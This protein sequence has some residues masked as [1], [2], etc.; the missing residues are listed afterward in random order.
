MDLRMIFCFKQNASL[1]YFN[2]IKSIKRQNSSFPCHI[3]L[4]AFLFTCKKRGFSFQLNASQEQFQIHEIC[5]KPCKSLSYQSCCISFD[6]QE[7]GL[8]RGRRAVLNDSVRVKRG[9]EWKVRKPK[10]KNTSRDGGS[11]A[12]YA[13]CTVDTVDTFY[14]LQTALHCLN[15]SAYAYMLLGKGQNA[16][17]MG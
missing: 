14:S 7:K 10:E 1:E 9:R 13:A 8:R 6:P 4:A 2:L 5:Q 16:I 12:L 11:T 15:S 3:R 17:G